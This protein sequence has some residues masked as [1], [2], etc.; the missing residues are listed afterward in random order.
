MEKYELP[1]KFVT[2]AKGAVNLRMFEPLPEGKTAMDLMEH[3]NKA[4]IKAATKFMG[5]GEFSQHIV[6][7]HLETEVIHN[8]NDIELGFSVNWGKARGSSLSKMHQETT[9]GEDY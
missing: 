1:F 3:L 5:G 7:L 8:E 9:D 6:A 4:L 2:H